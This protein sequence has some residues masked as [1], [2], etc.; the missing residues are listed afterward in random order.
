MHQKAE[1][2]ELPLSEPANIPSS[3]DGQQKLEQGP[4]EGGRVAWLQVFGSFFL[5]MNTWY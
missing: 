2:I 5:W 1:D 4:P 3:T